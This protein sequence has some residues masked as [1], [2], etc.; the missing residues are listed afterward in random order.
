MSETLKI[1]K[2]AVLGTGIMGAQIAAHLTNANIEVL[3]YDI[4][5]DIAQKGIE[6]SKSLKPS[7]FYN[8]KNISMITPLNYD[9][10]LDRL[11]ECDWIIEVIAERLDLKQSLYDKIKNHIKWEAKYNDLNKMIFF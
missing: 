8:P 9:E 2:V 3:A 1:N 6:A 11:S 4:S 5:Q 7:A 10:H